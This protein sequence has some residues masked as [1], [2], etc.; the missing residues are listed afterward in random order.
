DAGVVVVAGAGPD[1]RPFVA[2]DDVVAR[3]R[4]R[5][6]REAGVSGA[7]DIADA[8]AADQHAARAVADGGGFLDVRADRALA[9]D[10]VVRLVGDGDAVGAVVRDRVLADHRVAGVHAG[11]ADY[12]VV[13]GTADQD[14]VV[15]VGEVVAEVEGA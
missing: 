13:G 5:Q 1:A 11:A 15:A 10:V 2:A 12:V 8:G 7:D 6:W 3:C 14:A 9:D 4:R